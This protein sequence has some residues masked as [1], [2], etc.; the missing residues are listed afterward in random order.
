MNPQE[1]GV[2]VA[3]NFDVVT[4]GLISS[5]KPN[6]KAAFRIWIFAKNRSQQIPGVSRITSYSANLSPPVQWTNK[7]NG[8]LDSFSFIFATSVHI[9]FIFRQF[10]SCFQD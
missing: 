3:W 6:T 1:N 10:I 8:I 2:T 9:K 4:T 7:F 5:I